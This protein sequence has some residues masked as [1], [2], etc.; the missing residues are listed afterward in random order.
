MSAVTKWEVLVVW[1][2][3]DQNIIG[4]TDYLGCGLTESGAAG[5]KCS[6]IEMAR[7]HLY[8]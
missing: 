1:E 7:K 4:P 5:G 6:S 3:F 8:F 2:E